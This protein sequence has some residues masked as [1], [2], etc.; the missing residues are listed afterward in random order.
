MRDKKGPE[1]EGCRGTGGVEGRETI[2]R[3]Y[4]MRKESIFNN[5]KK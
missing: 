2:A 4:H 3:I 1:L 5:R